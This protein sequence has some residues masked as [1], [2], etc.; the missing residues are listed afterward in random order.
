MASN[1]ATLLRDMSRQHFKP[2]CEL[3]FYIAGKLYKVS[4]SHL[5]RWHHDQSSS[6]QS[7]SAWSSSSP[8][9]TTPHHLQI[10]N[11]ASTAQGGGGSFKARKPIGGA[12]CRDAWMAERTHWL[13][14]LQVHYLSNS[15]S[16]HLS[17]CQ[18][19]PISLFLSVSL[20]LSI[21]LPIYLLFV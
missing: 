13:F 5:S 7:S 19:L 17:L 12:G 14:S 11:A 18:P 9:S 6:S 21:P 15:L 10:W 8:A 20:S 2:H 1:S 4:M 16:M 3:T